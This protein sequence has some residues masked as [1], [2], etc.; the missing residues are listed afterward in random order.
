MWE[1]KE[2][3]R[4]NIWNLL[5]EKKVT[6]FPRPVKGRIPN[7]QGAERAAVRLM[8]TDEFA[9][10]EVVKVNP[11]SPQREVRGRVLESGKTLVMPSPRLR[12]G[13]LVLNPRKIP[14][15]FFRKAS[16][17]RGSFQFAVKTELEKLPCVDLIVCGSVAVTEEGV[18]I[19]KGG[20]YSDLEYGLLRE[21]E[22]VHENTPI[23]TS[24]HELQ[25]VEEA[26]LNEHDFT[27]D[28]ISTPE[29]LL[30]TKGPR[31]RPRGILWQE[32]TEKQ[33]REIPIL[34]KLRETQF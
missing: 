30:R 27:V 16:T 3:I 4:E 19:G 17:I 24:V 18:R 32:L 2:E 23:L 29:R 25:F 15:T 8:K 26:P 5:E 11:D 14:R 9:Q 10:S 20:G 6:R 7:F 13:F 28:L 33:T 31:V 22:L 12:E 21:Q 1:T 34:K